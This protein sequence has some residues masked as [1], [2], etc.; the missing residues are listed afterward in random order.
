MYYTQ[1][2]FTRMENSMRIANS[3][4]LAVIGVRSDDAG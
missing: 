4:P 2:V 1:N 3:S